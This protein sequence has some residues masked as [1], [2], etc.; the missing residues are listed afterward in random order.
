MA[1]YEPLPCPNCGAEKIDR[2]LDEHG[3]FFVQCSSCGLAGLH[4]DSGITAITTWNNLPR[5][6]TIIAWQFQAAGLAL[7]NQ[8]LIKMVDW[9]VSRPV[10]L[11][12]CARGVDYHTCLSQCKTCWKEAARRAVVVR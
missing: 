5:M 2:R 8:R 4:E 7:E 12:I 10:F 1:L 6:S 3:N 9:L 11:G